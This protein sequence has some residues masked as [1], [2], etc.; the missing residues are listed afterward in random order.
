[1][2]LAMHYPALPFILSC[3]LHCMLLY[4]NN[5]ILLS[6]IHPH[7]PISYKQKALIHIINQHKS[8]CIL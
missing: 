1:M 3:H 7:D 2:T 8:I 6:Y 4:I 5:A